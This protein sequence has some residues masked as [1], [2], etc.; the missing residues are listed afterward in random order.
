M[1]A[2]QGFNVIAFSWAF[3]RYSDPSRR[4]SSHNGRGGHLFELDAVVWT[5]KVI[6]ELGSLIAA[7]WHR[8]S[9]R[10]VLGTCALQSAAGPPLVLTDLHGEGS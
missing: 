1:S 5:T 3:T 10:R 4:G 6:N 8:E 9:L 7:A 2:A